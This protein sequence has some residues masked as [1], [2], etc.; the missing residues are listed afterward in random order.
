MELTGRIKKI[1]DIQNVNDKFKKREF[2]LVIDENTQYPQYILFQTT[3]EKCG[4]LDNVKLNE[5]VKVHF[6]IRGREWTASDG[7]TKYFVTLEAWKIEKFV[8]VENIPA[9]ASSSTTPR[10]SQSRVVS[11]HYVQNVQGMMSGDIPPSLPETGE[12]GMSS[13]ISMEDSGDLPF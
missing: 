1:M 4:L 3:Q 9:G 2:V 8:S 5:Q 13:D 7:Q 11:S 10:T 12:T 6:N